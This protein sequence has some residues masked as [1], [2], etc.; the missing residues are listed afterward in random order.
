MVLLVLQ[1]RLTTQTRATKGLADAVAAVS[2]FEPAAYRS[3]SPS[4]IPARPRRSFPT[5]A[6]RYTPLPSDQLQ[7]F[8]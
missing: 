5:F 4:P 6:F 7:P 3:N 8:P 1:A 2:L